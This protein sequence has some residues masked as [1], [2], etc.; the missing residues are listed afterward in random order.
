MN[1]YVGNLPFR[2]TNAE[3][4]G[5]FGAHGTVDRAAVITDRDTGRSR[6]FGFVEMPNREEAETAI[7]EL[8][9]YSLD[10]RDLRVNEAR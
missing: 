4:E 5:L 10:G 6:G 7:R 8:N 9:G 3:L 1:I 2:T